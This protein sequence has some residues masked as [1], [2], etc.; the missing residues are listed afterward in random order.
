MRSHFLMLS[1]GACLAACAPSRPATAPAPYL[2]ESPT[3]FQLVSGEAGPDDIGLFLAGMPVR[4][5][6]V[7]SGFQQT[8]DYQVHC[9]EM[10]ALW[11]SAAS[12]LERM[13]SWSESELATLTGADGTV[14]YPFGGPDLLHV[15]T[16]FPQ[17]RSFV[18][19]GLEPVGDV[20]ALAT[21]PPDELP[22]VLATFRQV[23]HAQ[24][25][26]GY[27]ITKD[28]RSD[29]QRSSLR[30]V[31]PILLS[32]VALTGGRVE[33]VNR[34]SAGGK[35]GV[36]MRYCDAAG[37]A[38]HVCYVEGD[39]SNSGFG[40]GYRQWLAG[41]GGDVTYFK[42]ASYLMHD[43]HFSQ[44]REFFLS[45]SRLILQ[46]DSGI[47]FRHFPHGWSL[48]LFG[49]YDRPIE[50]FS[51]YQQ[52]DLRQ[53]YASRHNSQIDFGTGYHVSA[54]EGNLLLSIKR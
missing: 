47:P 49:T 22:T 6:A 9:R 40:G 36:E 17:A 41:L 35:P 25:T 54:S 26:T 32:T 10:S 3:P 16:L 21:L 18:L 51:K 5:G 13:Q 43:N 8:V 2:N 19:M 30:G 39:L 29:L 45:Q 15:S 12:R 24:L 52:A 27:F 11:G 7:L 42:A 46:D 34:L 20:P 50:L 37:V 4:R 31:I 53:A 33:S 48:R 23:T 38:H 44:A 1:I 28:M 14:L